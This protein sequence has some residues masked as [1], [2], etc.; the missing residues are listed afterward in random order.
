MILSK[1]ANNKGDDQSARMRR[2]VC[3]FVVRKPQRQVFLRRGPYQADHITIFQADH[4][5][6]YQADHMTIFQADPM[7]IFQAELEEKDEIK[8]EEPVIEQP[9]QQ[10][11]ISCPDGL[12]IRYMLESHVGM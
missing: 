12:N 3:T 2:L 9:F 10:L 1:K 7:T 4:M 11:F 5:T 6:I 8:S